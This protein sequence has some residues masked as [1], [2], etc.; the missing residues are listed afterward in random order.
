MAK[1]TSRALSSNGPNSAAMRPPS[2]A[3]TV[4]VRSSSRG[5]ASKPAEY[6]LALGA[7]RPNVSAFPP[8]QRAQHG[9]RHDRGDHGHG[10][11]HPE[12]LGVESQP[13]PQRGHDQADLPP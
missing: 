5:R 8:D 11:D 12:E 13:E 2:W 6:S 7:L 9:R 10:D 1:I 3:N 4:I